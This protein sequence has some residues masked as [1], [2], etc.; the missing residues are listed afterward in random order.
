[1]DPSFSTSEESVSARLAHCDGAA[2]SA[3][4][5]A[6]PSEAFS[7]LHL[8]AVPQVSGLMLYSLVCLT[9]RL[10]VANLQF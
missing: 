5:A 6:E 2:S 9:T 10:S 4:S 1:M 3:D 7:I 8:E